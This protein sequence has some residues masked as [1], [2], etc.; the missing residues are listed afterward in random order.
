MSAAEPP[1]GTN[2]ARAGGSAAAQPQARGNHA[3][4]PGD[5]QRGLALIV[6][7]LIA[8]LA[9]AVAVS[10]ATAQSQWSAQVSH[11]RDQVQAQS[12]A[13]A[14]IQWARQILAAD[15]E[16]GPVDHLGEPWALPLPE[17]PV[18]NGV[19]EGRI[20]DAQGLFNVNNLAAGNA[21][22][23][24]RRFARLFA[25]LGIPSSTLA[26]IIDWIDADNVPQP[27]GA[28]DAWYLGQADPSLAANAPATRIEELGFVRGMTVPAMA[29][30]VRFCTSLPVVTPL[31]V[32]TAPLELLAASLDNIEPAQLAALVASRVAHPF[33]TVAEFRARLPAGASLGD[34]A[35]YSVGSRY[36]LVTVRARQGETVAQARA[37]IE[38]AEH[39]WPAIVWQTIE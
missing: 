27:D 3:S 4:A 36:F 6:A 20:V 18:E 9:A 21:A 1:Q 28:E 7:M 29:Q 38:R 11:R 26:S 14:G 16:A 35:M 33:G 17:T 34:E 37:L 19:V 23:E 15:A 32:N 10:V 13:L 31:N 25:T 12:I 8:A 5:R 22:S 39:A 2:S 30:L 24:R